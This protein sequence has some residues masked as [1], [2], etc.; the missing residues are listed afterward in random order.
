M[1]RRVNRA[2]SPQPAPHPAPPIRVF[3]LRA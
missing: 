3:P 1:T 2:R